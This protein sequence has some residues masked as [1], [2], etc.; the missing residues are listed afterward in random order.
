MLCATQV[1]Q[2]VTHLLWPRF[3][4]YQTRLTENG[5]WRVR[6]S[7]ILRCK[8]FHSGTHATCI[9]KISLRMERLWWDKASDFKSS[10]DSQW[11]TWKLWNHQSVKS[12]NQKWNIFDFFFENNENCK[13]WGILKIF[14]ILIFKSAV[15]INEHKNALLPMHCE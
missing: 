3:E 9:N 1:L 2:H 14:N 7:M 6:M 11:W 12:W 10:T 15:D 8:S 4:N 5:C 13:I